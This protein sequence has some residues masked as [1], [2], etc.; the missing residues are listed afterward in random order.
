MVATC[1][2]CVSKV[3]ILGLYYQKCKKAKLYICSLTCNCKR[4]M[5]EISVLCKVYM[6]VTHIKYFTIERV[7]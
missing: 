7:L 6:N 5:D 2:W 4:L 3:A 1:F